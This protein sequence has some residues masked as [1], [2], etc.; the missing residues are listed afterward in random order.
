MLTKHAIL[1]MKQRSISQDII[2]LL[3]SYGDIEY[4]KGKQIYSLCQ[5]SLKLLSSE[6]NELTTVLSKLNRVFVVAKGS[7]IITVGYKTKRLKTNR[8]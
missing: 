2:D 3:L 8:K 4:H 5:L 7:I 6:V 1:R